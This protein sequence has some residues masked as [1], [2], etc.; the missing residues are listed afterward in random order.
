MIQ[1]S[2]AYASPYYS[3]HRPHYGAR[4]AVAS[5]QPLASTAG[6]EMLFRGGNAVDAAIAM[7][8]ALTVLE[9]TSNGIGGD[10]FALVWDGVLH[11][12]NGSG[13]SPAAMERDRYPHGQIPHHGWLTVTVPGAVSAWRRLWKR[14]GK[15][16]FEALFEPAIR[17]AEA[18]F[19]VGPV[20]A[21]A[22]A[23]AATPM[24]ALQGPEY[25]PLQQLFFPQGRAPQPG[26]WWRSP[27]YAA[28]LRAIAQQGSAAFYQGELAEKIVAFAQQTGGLLTAAD[29]QAQK[30]EWV[31]PLS[32]QYRDVT[33][34]EL[35]PNTQGIAALL[36]LKILEGYTFDPKQN[37][38]QQNSA[39]ARPETLHL[40]IEAMKLAFAD[41]NA[42]IADPETMQL[43]PVALLTPDY[44]QAR[45]ALIQPDVALNQPEPGIPNSGTVYFCAADGE[46]MVSMIQSNYQDFGSGILI[47]ETGILLQ[48]RACGFTLQAGHPNELAPNKRPL[49][50]IIPGFLSRD[51]EPLGPFGVMG[52]QMQ[53]QGHLQLVMN[54]VDYQMNPQ[55]ALDLHRW[56]FLEG[57]RVLLEAGTSPQTIAALEALGHQVRI[58]EESFHFGKGQVIL[59]NPGGGLIAGSEPRADGCAIVI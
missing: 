14:W 19:P 35:P 29:L 50:T 25:E 56:R 10:A 26:E 38:P 13:R 22:W 46:L 1:Q 51:D 36:A 59:R 31:A 12:L 44:I 34:W 5:S 6:L 45:R 43:D 23:R 58:P 16:P 48:N 42:A 30:A 7:A 53:P 21:Q 15:L 2:D 41:V 49:H 28:T 39:W 57:Q 37:N 55:S 9:P 20:T 24:M 32:I 47:P 4:A 27:G 3:A 18:G 33:V 52:G 17:Y 40:Q 54:L 11:G 8:I